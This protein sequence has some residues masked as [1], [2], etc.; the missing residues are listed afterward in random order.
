MGTDLLGTLSFTTRFP[1][2]RS[3][4]PDR[5]A[6]PIQAFGGFQNYIKR[7]TTR[8]STSQAQST[9]TKSRPTS[10]QAPEFNFKIS[11]DQAP[12]EA[13]TP[14]TSHTTRR[15]ATGYYDLTGKPHDL[16]KQV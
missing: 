12:E 8:R 6:S 5:H 1:I 9:V 10:V 14:V 2:S 16:A 11:I 13:A 4:A 7:R 3:N 15:K